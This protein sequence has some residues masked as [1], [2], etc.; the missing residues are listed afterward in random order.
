MFDDNN[1]IPTPISS[2]GEFGLI[3]RVTKAFASYDIGIV[4]AVG[5]DCA[6]YEAE[7]NLY[8]L[9]T[10]DI[11]AEG[12]HFD[13]SYVPLKHLGYKL[14][15]VNLSD[16]Y[17]MNGIPFG[18]TIAIAVSNR[19][20]VEAMDELYEGI[21]LACQA[22][23]VDL[24][25]GDTSSSSAGTFISVTALGRVDRG[26]VCFRKGAKEGDLICVS[27]D[28]GAAYA[29]LQ[30]LEREK[31]VFKANPNLQPD[32]DDYDYVMARQLKPEP[33]ND[34]V[35]LLRESGVLPTSM[36]DV[37]DGLAS[38]I[39]HICKNSNC[40]ATVYQDKI[41]VDHQTIK[42][43]DEFKISPTTYALNGGEDYELLFTIKP[44]DFEKVKSMR[45]IS[46][47]GHITESV[48]GANISLSGGELVPLTAQGWDHFK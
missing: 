42:V 14:V 29:G 25:G 7:E 15:A 40:G 34:V 22:F 13:L 16:I 23:Q 47:I 46:I 24:L 1:F 31:A 19:F 2:L 27:G 10:T 5:D 45:E 32:L 30:V 28:L 17:A 11:L 38:E 33:R 35:N 12:V 6:V 20:S 9:I 18:I 26:R 41:P 48:T 39:L 36:I 43:A 21:K 3:D 37:S 44:A 4:K 8:H